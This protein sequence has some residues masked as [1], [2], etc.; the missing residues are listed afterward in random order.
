MN[1]LVK[2]L[3]KGKFNWL[4][5]LV[6]ITFSWLALLPR[7]AQAVVVPD[8]VVTKSLEREKDLAKIR[9]VLERK[10]VK[11]R[12]E[13]FGVNPSEIEQKLALLSDKEIHQLAVQ[14]DKLNPGGGFVE[15]LIAVLVLLGLVILI[16]DLV[17]VI[18]VIPKIGPKAEKKEKKEK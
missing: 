14:I 8:P 4:I 12:L 13:S 5:Y 16:L 7:P 9:S 15:T 2:K 10:E 17:G 18:D 11:S 6:L 3:Q 1:Y